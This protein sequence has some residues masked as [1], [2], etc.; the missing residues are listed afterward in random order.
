MERGEREDKWF[1]NADIEPHMRQFYTQQEIREAVGF[2]T[3]GQDK[4]QD[5]N[6]D[7]TRQ[8]PLPPTPDNMNPDCIPEN[9]VPSTP[10]FFS[11]RCSR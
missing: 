7:Q 8:A 10:V 6:Q 9:A 1:H 11:G 2:Y 4:K 5:Q 3:I